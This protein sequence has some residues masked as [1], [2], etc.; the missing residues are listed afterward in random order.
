L[1]EAI[2]GCDFSIILYCYKKTQDKDNMAAFVALWGA[3]AIGASYKFYKHLT[4]WLSDDPSMMAALENET[5]S[6]ETKAAFDFVESILTPPSSPL[7]RGLELASDDDDDE[8]PA[9]KPVE[10]VAEA[11]SV[12]KPQSVKP[13][14]SD[15]SPLKSAQ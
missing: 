11:K 15:P 8:E 6:V 12:E 3:A 2:N 9:A 14:V 5:P 10:K 4:A 1:T 7:K 13:V